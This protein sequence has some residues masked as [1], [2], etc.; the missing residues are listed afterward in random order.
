MPDTVGYTRPSVLSV[1]LTQ[2]R[3]AAM[4]KTVNRNKPLIEIVAT[5]WKQKPAEFLIATQTPFQIHF[6]FAFESKSSAGQPAAAPRLGEAEAAGVDGVDDPDLL[7]RGRRRGTGCG[8]WRHGAG[9]PQDLAKGGE[10]LQELVMG[11]GV[12]LGQG[13]RHGVSLVQNRLQG[14]LN[15][16]LG[17]ASRFRA[18]V[19]EELRGAC[20]G[21]AII[22]ASGFLDE[23]QEL[24]LKLVELNRGLRHRQLR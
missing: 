24:A 14:G 23:S 4:T 17:S 7:S 11:L 1:A 8:G 21:V 20:G 9:F 5:P 12:A 16:R 10:E 18:H 22:V 19:V 2:E 6:S 15:V 13:R 3:Q